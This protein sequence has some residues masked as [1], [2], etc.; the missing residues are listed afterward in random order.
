MVLS[1]ATFSWRNVTLK[2][3]LYLSRFKTYLKMRGLGPG[4]VSVVG[5]IR[6]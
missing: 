2:I 1:Y 3:R 5:P 4:V 6:V